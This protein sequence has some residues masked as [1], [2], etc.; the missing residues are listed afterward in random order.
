MFGSFKKGDSN[1]STI[2]FAQLNEHHLL[3]GVQPT[4]PADGAEAV[5]EEPEV[6]PEEGLGEELR[7]FDQQQTPHDQRT[8]QEGH[9]DGRLKKNVE[10]KKI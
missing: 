2:F 1:C 5:P 10:N 9:R 7:V 6:V 4:V 8:L 3:R